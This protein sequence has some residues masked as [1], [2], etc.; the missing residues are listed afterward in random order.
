MEPNM[1]GIAP[2]I[3]TPEQFL[4]ARLERTATRF[5]SCNTASA[6]GAPYDDDDPGLRMEDPKDCVWDTMRSCT[7]AP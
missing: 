1:A 5:P 4:L 7:G 6:M 3:G 2:G